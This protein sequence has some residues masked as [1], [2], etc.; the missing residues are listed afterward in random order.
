MEEFWELIKE[1]SS[2][3]FEPLQ[4]LSSFSSEL[5]K[6]TIY[7][8][9]AQLKR[10]NLKIN[11]NWFDSFHKNDGKPPEISR[12]IYDID[13][14]ISNETLDIKNALTVC[15]SNIELINKT[16][17]SYQEE[18]LSLFQNFIKN[19]PVKCQVNCIKV[20]KNKNRNR[21]NNFILFDFI[22]LHRGEKIGHLCATNGIT[23]ITDI[24]QP[25]VSDIHSNISIASCIDNLNLLG[26]KNEFHLFPIYDAANDEQIDK[27][28][29]NYDSATLRNNIIME[30]YSSLKRQNLFFG[31]TSYAVTF[32]EIPVQYDLI[33]EGMDIIITD[34]FGSLI[35][36]SLFILTKMNN[37]N[38]EVFEKNGIEY[39]LIESEKER[40]FKNLSRIKFSLGKVISKYCPD[41]GS[42]FDTSSNIMAVHPI[43]NR[44][45]FAL[46][47]FAEISN[48][49]LIINKLPIKF[50]NISKFLVKEFLIENG[51][52]SDNKCNLI[53]SRRDVTDLIIEDLMKIGF[54][55]EIIGQIGKKN[56]TSNLIIKE[57]VNQFIATRNKTSNLFHFTKT[58]DR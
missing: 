58:E 12:R 8:N 19:F 35:P 44:G 33:E 15:Q 1:Y 51:T 45:I 23:S 17:P 31:A 43:K 4:W 53:I 28:R 3:G 10:T 52:S 24:T 5:E 57:N 26:C 30:D 48:C 21:N 14:N 54:E 25:I 41:F 50:D 9:L 40:I 47:D 11:F 16:K 13:Y 6:E 46:K 39:S 38:I 20:I 29:E 49:E 56:N 37:N 34:K 32:N 22:K 27:I 2:A 36:L 55:P 18:N 42:K 7:S